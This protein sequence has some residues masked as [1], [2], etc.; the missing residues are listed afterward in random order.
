M[1]EQQKRDWLGKRDYELWKTG[2][3]EVEDFIP[4]Y[5]DRTYTVGKLKAM[6]KESFRCFNPRR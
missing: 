6:D 2:Q 4:P 3:Y 5:P 1:S